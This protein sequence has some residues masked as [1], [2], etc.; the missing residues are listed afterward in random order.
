MAGLDP[1]GVSLGGV[2][3]TSFRQDIRFARTADKLRIAYAVSGKGYPLVRAATWM[4]NVELDWRTSIFGPLFSEL[5]AS[6]TLYRYDARGY[7]L[8]EGDDTEIS[9]DSMTADLAAVVDGAQLRRFALWGPTSAGSATAIAYAARHPE[10]VSHLVL[11]GPMAR[12]ALRRP[13]ATQ[14]DRDGFLALVKLIELGWGDHNPAFRH[15]Q[16][17][18][19]FPRATPEQIGELNEL[20]RRSAAPRH[21]ARMVLAT[22]EAD[23]SGCLSSISCP[24]LILHCRGS[25]LMPIEEARL[26]ASSVSG[27]RFVPLESGNYVPIKG[28]PAFAQLIEQF[29]A[30]LPAEA[31]SAA[32][33]GLTAR[34]REVLD[35][36][37]R[38]LDNG[39]IASQLFVSEKTIRNTVSRIFDKLAVRSRAQAVVLARR[40]GL[41]D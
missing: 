10:R 38:G 11:T 26:I 21:A 29:R 25:L 12:G 17:N 40:A 2:F 32:L 18:R 15:M 13:H 3:P 41:G 27:A 35:L 34:E 28:E 9:I 23:V 1:H 24:V 16:T 4:S 31:P 22:G 39:S 8:S 5:S 20:L 7:G 14:D 6:Y 30:F 33:A 36:V 19:M 37:A